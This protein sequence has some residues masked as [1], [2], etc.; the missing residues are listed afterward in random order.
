MP[1]ETIAGEV[2]TPF[3]CYSATAIRHRFR[4]YTTHFEGGNTLVCYAVKANSNQSVL[5]LLAS[6]GAGAD[7]VSEGELKRALAAGIPAEKIVFSGV[8]KSRHEMAFALEQKI[9]QFNVESEPELDRLN[10]VA[11]ANGVVAPVAFRI[12]PDVDARTHHK[13]TTGKAEN[14]F[15]VPASRARAIYR[16]AAGR[17]GVRIQG[18]DMHIGSQLTALEPFEQA[19]GTMAELARTLRAEGHAIEVLDIGGGLG[20]D[21]GD[22]ESGPPGLNDYAA[23]AS[24][25]LGELGCRL[26]IEPGRSVVGAAGVL[27]SEV[28]YRKDGEERQFLIIDA[29]MN[30]LL[31]PS[32]Y[33]ARHRIRPVR[34]SGAEPVVFDVVGPICETGDTFARD[35]PL[36]CL[37]SGDRVAIM[38]AGAYGAVMGSFYNTHPLAPEVLVDGDRFRVVRPRL[39]PEAIMALDSEG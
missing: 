10:D 9:F 25:I 29:G 1:L 26:V 2:G 17:P 34:R 4:E 5:K 31:R 38:D 33:D 3:Y 36:P 39:T 32:L 14:K 20:I 37:Q 16:W 35:V 12:N 13:I 30:D 8:G 11:L 22:G 21:Y 15:G 18:I 27:V 6:M 24:K 19:F 28:L 23:L 7:V